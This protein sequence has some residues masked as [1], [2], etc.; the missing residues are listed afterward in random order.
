MKKW[1]MKGKNDHEKG[2]ECWG[3]PGEHIRRT[4]KLIRTV[5]PLI[6][7]KRVF[8]ARKQGNGRDV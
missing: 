3:Y 7:A 5:C 2:A 8:L 4:L 6:G 1:V